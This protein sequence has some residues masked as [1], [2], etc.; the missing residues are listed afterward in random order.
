MFSAIFLASLG[1]LSSYF[2]LALAEYNMAEI[3]SGTRGLGPASISQSLIKALFDEKYFS[4]SV[5]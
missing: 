4:I 1:K 3:T 2:M 5:I